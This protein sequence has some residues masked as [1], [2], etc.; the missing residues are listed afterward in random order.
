MLSEGYELQHLK[1]TYS[2]LKIPE[3]DLNQKE[4]IMIRPSIYPK[5]QNEPSGLFMTA[6]RE[7]IG[8]IDLDDEWERTNE[9]PLFV[10]GRNGRTEY[11]GVSKSNNLYLSN[12]TEVI[13]GENGNE[14][15][16]GI[17]HN[18]INEK[19]HKIEIKARTYQLKLF[20]FYAPFNEISDF[21]LSENLENLELYITVFGKKKEVSVKYLQNN[22]YVF[23]NPAKDYFIIP[24]NIYSVQILNIRIFD[25]LGNIVQIIDPNYFE[26]CNNKIHLDNLKSGL[27]FVELV[28]PTKIEFYK[29]LIKN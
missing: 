2:D 12:F 27:Y 7:I 10:W 14:I 1:I 26:N 18:S 4:K 21:P 11:G 6:R 8:Q 13:N 16:E 28:K 17:Y 23:P 22:E 5:R 29:L 24:N 9:S 3:F 19:S 25:L 15:V 20:N